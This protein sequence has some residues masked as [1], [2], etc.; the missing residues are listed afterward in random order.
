M[1]WCSGSVMTMLLVSLLLF[2]DFFLWIFSYTKSETDALRTVSNCCHGSSSARPGNHFSSKIS[3]TL[4]YL[5]SIEYSVMVIWREITHKC[6]F[7]TTP[8]QRCCFCLATFPE[9]F[10]GWKSVS[11]SGSFQWK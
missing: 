9:L 7:F 11:I 6:S 2:W 5:Q 10:L 4:L 1:G 8:S 3:K